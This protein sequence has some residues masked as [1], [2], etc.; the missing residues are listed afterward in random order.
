MC[1]ECGTPL[2][3]AES[4]GGR[5]GAGVHPRARSPQGK[6]K[7]QIK[8]APGGRSTG[9]GCSPRPSGSGF[10]LAV[11]L[12]PACCSCW[13]RSARVV[14]ACRA[15]GA[16]PRPPR[17]RRPRPARR[18]PTPTTAAARR[19]PATLRPLMIASPARQSTPRSS[20]RSRSASSRSSRPACCRSCPATCRRS[21][22]SR[23][24][25]C[26]PASAASRR[27]CCPAIV[28]CLSFTV[29]VR[30]ARHDRDR[31]RLDA[32]ATRAATL[33]KV[34]GAVI[35]ALG[36]FFVL[37]PFVPR[38]EPRV[39]PGRADLARRLRRP[40]RRRARRS[41]WPGRRA[42]A[43]RSA[44]I[45]TAAVDPGHRRPRAASCWRSTRPAWRCRSCSRAVAFNRATDRVPLAARPLPDRHRDLRRRADRDGRAAVHRRA[46]AAQHRGPAAR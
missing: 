24:P 8:A 1:V 5:P 10:D 37:T 17:G 14:F 9:P 13:R 25:R 32:A 36:V 39:A 18:S 34:A 12:V 45:L 26:R 29:D 22:A 28:F 2:N 31:A 35:V 30:R 44:S 21:P 40:A 16:A 41:R 46:H 6:T 42:S 23:W 15:G 43:R 7:Q 33:D 11:W 4:P 19:R 27:C 3:V 20:P 38:A